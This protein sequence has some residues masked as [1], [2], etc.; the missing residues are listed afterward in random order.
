MELIWQRNT[1]RQAALVMEL[2]GIQDG[3]LVV[4]NTWENNSYLGEHKQKLGLFPIPLEQE[5]LH[6]VHLAFPHN[7]LTHQALLFIQ[8]SQGNDPSS[9]EDEQEK[10]G[11]SRDRQHMVLT[12]KIGIYTTQWLDNFETTDIIGFIAWLAECIFP[13]AVTIPEKNPIVNQLSNF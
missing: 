4:T 5:S 8:L 1:V 13:T 10:Q 3:G 2:H 11:E 7:S 9:P 6:Q 12:S